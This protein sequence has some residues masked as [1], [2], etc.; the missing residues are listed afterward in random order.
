MNVCS[1]TAVYPTLLGMYKAWVLIQSGVRA[2]DADVM[3][4]EEMKS[5]EREL[6]PLYVKVKLKSRTIIS[7]IGL[8]RWG[9]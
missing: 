7:V 1:N 2:E 3:R 6:L 4:V 5:E 9:P 8:E